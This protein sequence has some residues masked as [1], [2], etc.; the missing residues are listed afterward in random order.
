[1][2]ILHAASIAMETKRREGKEEKE[3]HPRIL[4]SQLN[5]VMVEMLTSLSP[6]WQPFQATLLDSFRVQA[7]KAVRWQRGFTST[8]VLSAKSSYYC[9]H[10]PS[11]S[12]WRWSS[13]TCRKTSG[14]YSGLI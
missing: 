10:G 6:R 13:E 7:R 5:S 9:I 3:T 14:D 11:Y 1:M 12:C 2:L 8:T 4:V